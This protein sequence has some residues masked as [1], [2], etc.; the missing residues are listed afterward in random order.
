MCRRRVGPSF[1]GESV[2]NHSFSTFK[3]FGSLVSSNLV[4]VTR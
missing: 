3:G 2:E 4:A 1:P